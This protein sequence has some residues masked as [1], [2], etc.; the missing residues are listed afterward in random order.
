MHI[1][2]MTPEQIIAFELP[3]GIPYVYDFDA[4]LNVLDKRFWEV[5]E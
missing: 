5:P 4:D 1:E 2:Q 3:T